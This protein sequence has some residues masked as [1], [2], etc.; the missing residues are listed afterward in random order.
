MS[1]YEK[2]AWFNLAVI[3][4]TLVIYLALIPWLGP[5]RAT[6]AFGLLGLLGAGAFFVW[7]RR[8]SMAIIADERDKIIGSRAQLIAFRVF[9]VSFVGGILA[10][11]KIYEQPGAVPAKLLPLIIMAGFV[12]FMLVQSVAILVQYGWGRRDANG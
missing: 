3:C 8:G 10:V 7:H 1:Q 5:E 4:I 11:W 6:G 2:L 9:W 12:V